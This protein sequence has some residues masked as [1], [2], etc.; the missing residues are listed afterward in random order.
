MWC[1]LPN[2]DT[3]GANFLPKPL[4]ERMGLKVNEAKA[5]REAIKNLK[6]ELQASLVAAVLSGPAE[7]LW[8]DGGQRALARLV[9]AWGGSAPKRLDA[10]PEIMK[11]LDDATG[12]A[13]A[14]DHI[15][16]LAD[17]K[18]H[19]RL[20]AGVKWRLG[21]KAHRGR[22][23][24]ADSLDIVCDAEDTFDSEMLN[25]V[26]LAVPLLYSAL[27]GGAE[28]ANLVV[29]A[30]ELALKCLDKPGLMLPLGSRYFWG[31]SEGKARETFKNIV[32]QTSS[33]DGADIAEIG[34]LVG[35]A[36]DH[37]VQL[38]FRSAKAKTDSDLKKLRA[39]LTALLSGA[40][41]YSDNKTLL[42][43]ELIRSQGYSAICERIKSGKIAEGKYDS[44][45]LL[46]APNVVARVAT[47]HK[48]S[49]E[50]A[51][52]YLQLLTLHD[53]TTANLKLWNDWTTA[54]IG[55]AVKELLARKLILEAKRARAGRA[56]FIPGGW[57]P[58][59]A[60]L[61]PIESWKLPLYEAGRNV[62]TGKLEFPLCRILPLRPLGE[63]FAA[64][65]ERVVKG[66]APKYEEV[67]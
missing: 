47:K 23:A 20:K 18:K 16:A 6:P 5:A 7:D 39:A 67:S 40:D 19:P 25:V 28:A 17:P 35:G 55:K 38:G 33:K 1:G 36:N 13:S 64:A 24:G 4:R 26:T 46:S 22:V 9:E 44:N 52:L 66:D 2:F 8:D 58:L 14:A 57:E 56:V 48:L 15:A 31:Q 3:W 62:V 65:W 54:Q 32:G 10:P 49:E 37:T 12:Y 42:S 41:S 30:W 59:K 11:A 51:V 60:P 53:P 61:L 21:E 45:P 63:L 27:P 43:F 34:L 50:A 29:V